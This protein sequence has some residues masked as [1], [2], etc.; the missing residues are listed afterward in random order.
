MRKKI[1]V[2]GSKPNSQLPDMKFH[3]IY[4]SNGSAEKTSNYFKKYGEIEHNCIIG[5][6]HYHGNI[7]VNRKVSSSKID[8]LIVRGTI[9]ISKDD[10]IYSPRIIYFNN[11]QQFQIQSKFFNISYFTFILGE[12]DYEI[13]FISKIKHL[14]KCIKK[15]KFFGVST[16]FFSL[17]YAYL[18]NPDADIIVSGI[19]MKEDM[20][21]YDNKNHGFINRARV[22]NFF[23][24]KTGNKFLKNIE[25][26]DEDLISISKIK[27]WQ[28]PIF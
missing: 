15:K 20:S 26:L 14:F 7:E 16:G 24:K 18:N 11:Y 9:K 21:Q 13:R 10:F 12:L 17:I 3:K 2:L 28:G 22:D 5:A 4:S 8:N 1:L 27:R 25:S 19:G 6:E 23:I